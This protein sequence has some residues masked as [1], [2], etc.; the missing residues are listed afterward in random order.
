MFLLRT[1]GKVVRAADRQQE[2]RLLGHGFGEP[3]RGQFMNGLIQRIVGQR[4]GS[5]MH[6]H[7]ALGAKIQVD[8]QRFVQIDVLLL[9]KPARQTSADGDERKVEAAALPRRVAR[10]QP[11]P[12]IDEV[13][14]VACV[15]GEEPMK[16]RAQCRPGAPQRAVAVAQAA[17]RPVL[18]GSE[19]K[20]HAAVHMPFPPV[21]LHGPGDAEP[22]HPRL[23]PQGHEVE[24]RPARLPCQRLHA[25]AV[26]M[27]VVIVRDQHD[28]DV[29]Q[30]LERNARR[31]HPLGSGALQRR[32]AQ[33]KDR[34]REHVE[35][36][37]L[38]QHGRVTDPG[39]GRVHVRARQGIAADEVKIG[40]HSWRRQAGLGRQ[41]IADPL[42]LPA[43]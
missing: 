11:L 9:H 5:P 29:R 43:Q 32:G 41:V 37:G 33:G 42:P 24:R 27:I 1:F 22:L 8:L 18:R 4:E 34:I 36:A 10:R 14:A 35:P 15:A 40:I 16:I 26:E 31:L 39:G 12:G 19:L 20:F 21:E 3:H 38:H 28:I 7:A 6:P 25:A 17:A 30:I 23:Q 2:K 13:P